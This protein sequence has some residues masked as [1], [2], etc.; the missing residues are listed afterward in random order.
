VTAMD[1]DLRPGRRADH[2]PVS[3]N[4]IAVWVITAAFGAYLVLTGIIGILDK[5]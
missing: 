1:D 3:W 4:R 5:G 2:K